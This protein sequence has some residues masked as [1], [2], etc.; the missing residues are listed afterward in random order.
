M[1]KFE[2]KFSSA[3]VSPG[4]LLWKVSNLHQRQQ[5]KALEPL[6]LTPTLFSV[7][8]C[9]HYL[10]EKHESVAQSDVCHHAGIDKM[11]VSDVTKSLVKKN[12]VKLSKSKTDRRS[13][14][15]VVTND[16]ANICNKALKIIEQLDADFFGDLKSQYDFLVIMQNLARLQTKNSSMSQSL[17]IS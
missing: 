12:F 3:S 10:L 16:G 13:F 5:K 6:G 2:S 14:N 9:Y 8:A 11:L 4:F 7:L 1:T 15:V 17:R